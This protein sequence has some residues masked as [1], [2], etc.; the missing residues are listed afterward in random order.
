M[1]ELGPMLL[2][3]VDPV[4]DTVL[5]GKITFVGLRRIVVFSHR[6]E[7]LGRR[8][9]RKEKKTLQELAALSEQGQNL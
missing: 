7:V 8:G 4:G 3:V 5:G 1:L 2:S 9:D 6:D